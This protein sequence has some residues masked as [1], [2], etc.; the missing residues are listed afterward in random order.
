M[1]R[2]K[3]PGIVKRGGHWHIDKRIGG[4]RICQ[5]TE[6][7]ELEEAEATL[8]RI[9]EETRQARVYGVRPQRSFEQAAA[10]FIT[11]NAH[12]RSI[13]D[14]VSRLSQLLPFIGQL[15]LDRV[16]RGA[17]DSFVEKRRKEDPEAVA[18][19]LEL[20]KLQDPQVPR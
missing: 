6:S 20:L 11:E 17:L 19:A 4:R 12:K 18:E 16:H 7:A 1:G 14:D 9:I 15:P 8:A 10:K 3:V 2:K 13:N 5:S